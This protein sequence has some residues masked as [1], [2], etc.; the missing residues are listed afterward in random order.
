[1]PFA[2]N[3]DVCFV[4][5]TGHQSL[6]TPDR[7]NNL[8]KRA[9]QTTKGGESFRTRRPSVLQ[10]RSRARPGLNRHSFWAGYAAKALPP[11][12]FEPVGVVFIGGSISSPGLAEASEHGPKDDPLSPLFV[13]ERPG[14]KFETTINLTLKHGVRSALE[15]ARSG[16][17]QVIEGD[18]GLA[19]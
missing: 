13:A 16:V 1:V 5:L 6:S 9:T 14:G 7:A 3:T 19:I 8:G 17:Q 10:E 15:Y 4:N 18:V 11:R 2:T 12:A